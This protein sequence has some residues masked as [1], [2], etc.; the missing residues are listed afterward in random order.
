VVLSK[1]ATQRLA[2]L[3]IEKQLDLFGNEVVTALSM[4]ERRGGQ[5]E[6]KR[7]GVC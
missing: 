5:I 4:K 1:T 2:M 7:I 6:Q 3:T